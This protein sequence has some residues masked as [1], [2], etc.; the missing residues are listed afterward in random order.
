MS[1]FN[2]VIFLDHLHLSVYPYKLLLTK[3]GTRH[4]STFQDY[5]LRH[6]ETSG[7]LADSYVTA[8]STDCRPAIT[9]EP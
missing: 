1:S 9:Q 5:E 3:G 6:G 2:P 4:A 7:S 8:R